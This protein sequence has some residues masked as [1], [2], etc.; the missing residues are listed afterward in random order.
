MSLH[1]LY[2]HPV[3]PSSLKLLLHSPWP[4][5]SC[6]NLCECYLKLE[7]FQDLSDANGKG[8]F[9]N[10][11][12]LLVCDLYQN[13]SSAAVPLF[14]HSWPKLTKLVLDNLAT[15]SGK[16]VTTIWEKVPMLS[17]PTGFNFQP[18]DVPGLRLLK[19]SHFKIPLE[20]LMISIGGLGL[21][22]LDVSNCKGITGMMSGLKHHTFAFLDTLLLSNCELHSQDLNVLAQAGAGGRLPQ[23]KHLDISKNQMCA[24]HLDSLFDEECHWDSLLVLNMRQTPITRLSQKRDLFFAHK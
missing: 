13:G 4:T 10:L 23:L 1:L 18:Q 17:D 12:S 22:K 14:S 6:L 8:F 24:G 5:L 16:E 20:N 19:F 11:R 7:G 3:E 2:H 21:T 9:P 15:R